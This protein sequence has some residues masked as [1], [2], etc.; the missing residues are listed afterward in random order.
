M[1][2]TDVT[3]KNVIQNIIITGDR[4]TTRNHKA[5]SSTGVPQI[6]LREFPEVTLRP[7]AVKKAIREMEWFMNGDPTCPQELSDWW[8]GQL[9]PSGKYINGY[10]TMLRRWNREYDQVEAVIEQ[11]KTHPNSRRMITTTWE[12]Y[13]MSIITE[14]NQNPACPTTCHGTVTQYFVRNGKLN[15]TTYQRS[16]DVLL[17]VPHNWVQYWAY[18]VW[19]AYRTNLKP[20]SIRW[21]FGDAHI[22]DEKSHLQVAGIITQ[23]NGPIEPGRKLIYEPTSKNFIASDFKLVGER[24]KPV[25]RIRPKLL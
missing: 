19:L 17:G 15:L 21:I 22:Y 2:N 18:M 12:P 23:A 10:G 1:T 14:T 8:E 20:G 25:T 9:S 16:A 13:K 6:I 3:Y 5:I 11:I 7:T 4:L 24:P